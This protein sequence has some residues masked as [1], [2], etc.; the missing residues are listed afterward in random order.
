MHADLHRSNG[1]LT[2]DC[3]CAQLIFPSW[4]PL[5]PWLR[6]IS[7][8][9]RWYILYVPCAV[10]MWMHKPLTVTVTAFVHTA[11][12][13]LVE[14]FDVYGNK[15]RV[16]GEQERHGGCRYIMSHA[17]C[18]VRKQICHW[19]VR[20]SAHSRVLWLVIAL[21]PTV[22]PCHMRYVC[23]S[24]PCVYVCCFSYKCL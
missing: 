18:W 12:C 8:R 16:A 20:T 13:A 5:Y 23:S 9:S 19:I 4:S 6:Q 10:N 14:G 11:G 21:Q 24:M 15:E 2:S 17:A 3:R 1:L 22:P 7:L